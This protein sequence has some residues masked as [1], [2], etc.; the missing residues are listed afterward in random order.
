MHVMHQLLHIFARV[1]GGIDGG[2]HRDVPG[3]CTI[4]EDADGLKV[5]ESV[6][7]DNSNLAPSQAFAQVYDDIG[8]PVGWG[9]PPVEC[10]VPA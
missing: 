10:R 2:S 6:T 9:N 8:C 1:R 4:L 7:I 5:L 3:L